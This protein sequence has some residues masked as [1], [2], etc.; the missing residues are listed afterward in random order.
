MSRRLG[1]LLVLGLLTGADDAKPDPN[2][3]DLEQMQG[4][5][6]AV[7]METNGTRGGADE[8]KKFTLSVKKD[9]L[10]IKVN[11]EDHVSAK[12]VLTVNKKPK[13]LDLV[14]ETGP[15]YKG[16]YEVDGDTLKLCFNLSSDD[17]AERPK[18]FKAEEDS[19][20]ALFTWKRTK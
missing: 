15:V 20:S 18:E 5:W 8:V 10:T 16:I 7:A 17:D 19:H 12:L 4:T 13:E 2:K 3:K 11:G 6:H 9:G 1:I 14:Q